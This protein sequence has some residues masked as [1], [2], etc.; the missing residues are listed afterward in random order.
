[1][2]V[3][4]E[5]MSTGHAEIDKAQKQFIAHI[6]QFETALRQSG[7]DTAIGLF[8]TGLYDQAAI[9]FSREEKVQRESSFPFL[10]AHHREHRVLL[11]RL[12]GI[13]N[14]Y[15]AMPHKA[16]HGQLLQDLAG[17]IKDWVSHHMVQSDV[18]LRRYMP[19][20]PPH[21]PARARP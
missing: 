17:L 21:Q 14:Q 3:W 19:H 20:H 8:L 12:A 10:D 4:R 15:Q 1:M 2:L 9:N 16:D 6:N 18:M 5:A 11:D 7:P 13:Q